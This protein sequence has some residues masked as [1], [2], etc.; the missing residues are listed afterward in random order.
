MN[1]QE[2]DLERIIETKDIYSVFQPIISL[3]TGEVL[4]YEALS[5]IQHP[6]VICGVEDLFE[7]AIL[8]KKIW[9]LEK[10]CRKKAF[11]NF[12]C[13]ENYRGKKLFV[14]VNPLV[15]KD[16]KFRMGFTDEHLVNYNIKKENIVFEITEKG[17]ITDLEGF[18]K[19]LDHYKKQNYKIAMDDVGAGNSGL[20]MISDIH[21]GY[22]KLD[23]KLIRDIHKNSLKKAIVN[24]MM[25]LSRASGIEVIAE[26]IETEKEL[27]TLI[28]LGVQYGQ[29]FYLQRP[30]EKIIEIDKDLI[31]L[32]RTLSGTDVKIIK[33]SEEETEIS[34]HDTAMSIEQGIGDIAK[35]CQVFS[36]ETKGEFVY[37]YFQKNLY[38]AEICIV[39]KTDRFIGC[40]TRARAIEKF[41]GLYGYSLN[42]KKSITDLL[43][44]NP[45]VVDCELSIEAATRIAMNR[46]A[47]HLYDAIVVTK[48]DKFF[49]IV[50]LRD[51]V[52]TFISIQLKKAE[53]ENPL[54]RLPGNAVIQ[55]KIHKVIQA[56]KPFS[57]MYLDLD[58]FKAYNDAYGFGN[59]DKMIC[60]MAKSIQ[61]L[62]S[63]KD[64][65]GHIGGD[66]FVI[67]SPDWNTES[68]YKKIA[69]DFHKNISALYHDKDWEKG[70]IMAKGRDGIQKEYP[71]VTISAAVFSNEKE[72][73]VNE[74]ELYIRIAELKK[75]S[76]N[77]EGNSFCVI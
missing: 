40:V 22:L 62:S 49:G 44:E 70:F 58:N 56:Q 15:M 9:K 39:D 7:S 45:L 29:G 63:K 59:G 52:L 11:E 76:K 30:N 75:Q 72:K 50:T 18:Q 41:G 43:V 68:L 55:Q 19:T 61:K 71:I 73:A 28:N 48:E 51:L 36:P 38:T 32:I 23:M 33:S 27:E 16:K 47:D 17:N 31:H 6:E 35:P 8:F 20:T 13:Q 53:D 46:R 34:L 37:E 65:I 77:I 2:L 26:G 1:E 54:T 14:N 57:I 4:G 24:S 10:L 3:K 25:E 74:E 12:S 60:Q 66:D 21:P 69:E 64:F 42:A 67:I 5:R